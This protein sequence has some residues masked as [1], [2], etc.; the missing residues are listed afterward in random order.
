MSDYLHTPRSLRRDNWRVVFRRG[1]VL[2]RS[3]LVEDAEFARDVDRG[4]WMD[5]PLHEWDVPS[6]L[7]RHAL[8]VVADCCYC[9]SLPDS[10]C[11][12]CNGTRPTPARAK[13]TT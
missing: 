2:V 1:R 5:I 4:Q 8:D 10:G 9:S 6:E 3:L 7:E 13:E 12:F 11:D